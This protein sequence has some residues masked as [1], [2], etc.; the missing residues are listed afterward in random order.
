MR[1]PAPRA[2]ECGGPC[3]G[4]RENAV[5]GGGSA[6]QLLYNLLG[7]CHA[8]AVVHWRDM[9]RGLQSWTLRAELCFKEFLSSE[10]F[11]P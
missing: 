6:G 10:V 9:R 8:K 11:S 2:P 3:R 7:R 1:C 5:G 4:L